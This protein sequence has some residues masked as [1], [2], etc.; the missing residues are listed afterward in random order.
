[1]TQPAS[2]YN[3]NNRKAAHTDDSANELCAENDWKN[4]IYL[5]T[6]SERSISLVKPGVLVYNQYCKC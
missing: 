6:T 2:C 4:N 5:T 3:C 1:M